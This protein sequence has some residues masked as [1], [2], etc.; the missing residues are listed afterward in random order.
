MTKST[1]RN[2]NKARLWLERI[3]LVAGIGALGVWSGQKAVTTIWQ[4]WANHVFDTEVAEAPARG[5]LPGDGSPIASASPNAGSSGST[6]PQAKQARPSPPTGGSLDLAEGNIVGRL[7]IPRL[8]LSSMVREGVGEST[9]SVAL[10]HIPNTALPGQAGNV[11][12]AGHRDT[13]FR[14]LRD[15]RKDDLIRLETVSSGSYYYQVSSVEVVEPTD[16]SVLRAGKD[17][18]LTLVTCF[19]FNY[20]GAAPR[21]FIV[22]ARQVEHAPRGVEGQQIS[23]QK[24]VQK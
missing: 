3:L 18:E 19:P 2:A 9:L 6:Q 17:S 13:L 16:V 12:L 10:G 1:L 23:F 7:S 24:A 22:K 15:I 21:R 8:N 20:I 14:G 4:A 5:A 11:A